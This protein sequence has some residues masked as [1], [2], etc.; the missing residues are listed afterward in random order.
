M[1][2]LRIYYMFWLQLN[3]DRDDLPVIFMDSGIHAREWLS[4]S[5]L[6]YITHQ[7]GN[8]GDMYIH[9]REWFV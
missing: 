7:V 3:E 2:K 1:E 5:T 6:I 9:V 8:H 4:V